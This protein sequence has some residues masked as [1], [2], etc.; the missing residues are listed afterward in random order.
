MKIEIEYTDKRTECYS[1]DECCCKCKFH[2]E[3]YGHPWYN[4]QSIMDSIGIYVCTSFGAVDKTDDATV[5]GKH[6]I[7]EMFMKREA[8]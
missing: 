6:G 3:V 2:F 8:N 5:S 7:C 4:G 1:A